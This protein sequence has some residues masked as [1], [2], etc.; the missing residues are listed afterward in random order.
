MVKLGIA[1]IF[2]IA[3][4]DQTNGQTES[5]PVW[6]RQSVP[7][8]VEVT[9]DVPV[10]NTERRADGNYGQE[11]GS[12]YSRTAFRIDKGQRFQMIEVLG[13][14]GCRIE[15]Q[16]A[17]HNLSS[18]PWLPGFRDHQADIFRIVSADPVG[19]YR[20]VS[21]SEW[22]IDLYLESDG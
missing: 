15:Y 12:L 11:R 6:D 8:T 4:S 21:E 18:C 22:S 9:R 16:G 17:Q 1:A 7:I 3:A 14:G 20:S 10:K 5:T 19:H 13:E 2:L